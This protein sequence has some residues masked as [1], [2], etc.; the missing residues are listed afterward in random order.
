MIGVLSF[1]YRDIE[2]GFRVGGREEGF[3][4]ILVGFDFVFLECRGLW[5]M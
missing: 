4:Y 5:G 3:F 1:I 2:I